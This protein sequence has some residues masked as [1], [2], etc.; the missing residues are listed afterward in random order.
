MISKG[1]R[2]VEALSDRHMEISQATTPGGRTIERADDIYH[3]E[4]SQTYPLT[5]RKRRERS[6]LS[7]EDSTYRPVASHPHLPGPTSH[8]SSV[9]A[10]SSSP[11]LTR[12]QKSELVDHKERLVSSSPHKLVAEPLTSASG[13]PGDDSLMTR[14]RE[15]NRLAAQRFRS[16]KKGYQ[17][18]LEDRVRQLEDERDGLLF[19][20]GEA[21]GHSSRNDSRLG[22]PDEGYPPSQRLPLATESL[23]SGNARIDSP[24]DPISPNRRDSVEGDI[25]LA[26]LESANRKLQEEIR[27]ISEENNRLLEE[28]MDWR[29]WEMEMHK[30]SRHMS[31]DPRDNEKINVSSRGAS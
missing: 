19:R 24:S 3:W 14:R 4:G 17:D 26:A 21:P 25:R 15:A 13:H 12:L 20:L 10:L 23:P 9:P 18:S 28:V 11:L 31:Q 29:R 6:L 5:V 16:R 30:H 1:M 22:P 2:Q 27:L 7:P 8:N